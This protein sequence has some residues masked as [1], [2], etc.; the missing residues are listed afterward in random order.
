MLPGWV[1]E[2]VVDRIVSETAGNPLAL[3]ELPRGLTASELA[4]GLGVSG[5]AGL[6]GRIEGSFRR[7]VEAL[8]EATRRLALLAA[9][10]PAA[11]NWEK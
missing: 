4:G 6:S 8:P 11:V 3:L 2:P 5:S 7:R 10:D 1:T 9:A